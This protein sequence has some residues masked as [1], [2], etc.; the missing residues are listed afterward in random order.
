MGVVACL[1][2]VPDPLL[3]FV[4]ALLLYPEIAD[5][6]T[7]ASEHGH[8]EF[9]RDRR[10]LPSFLIFRLGQVSYGGEYLFLVSLELLDP[11][12]DR[13]FIRLILPFAISC[14]KDFDLGGIGWHW[15]LDNNVVCIVGA[16]E[17]RANLN[18]IRYS[19]I[20]WVLLYDG[21]DFERQINILTHA[22]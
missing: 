15:D 12:K 3:W 6:Q 2:D 13:G 21:R 19:S 10:L 1:R 17:S 7:T 14:R 22:I 20:I 16:F 5:P 11:P 4:P 18:R 8:L 9:H